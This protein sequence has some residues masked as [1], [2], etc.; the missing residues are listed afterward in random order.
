M[1]MSHEQRI[2][3][4]VRR[5]AMGKEL[6]SKIVRAQTWKQLFSTPE[7]AETDF[8]VNIVGK[9]RKEFEDNHTLQKYRVDLCPQGNIHVFVRTN[10]IGSS[11]YQRLQDG[12]VIIESHDPEESIHR[13][14]ITATVGNINHPFTIVNTVRPDLQVI[15][16][17]IQQI[18]TPTYEKM[19][20][21]IG[22]D[23]ISF[24]TY[25]NGKPATRGWE[26]LLLSNGNMPQRIGHRI[27]PH[28]VLEAQVKF[29]TTYP[30]LMPKTS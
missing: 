5:E 24:V 19:K 1:S 20:A 16:D 21:T 9:S 8:L 6:R 12:D 17:L 3:E 18:G 15:L 25:L 23:P 14:I 11:S 4:M 10:N 26:D 30:H 28:F 27:F 13:D 7:E 29:A 2:A 22:T